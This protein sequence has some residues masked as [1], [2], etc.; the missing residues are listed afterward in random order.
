[1]ALAL[2][3]HAVKQAIF[4]AVGLVACGPNVDVTGGDGE[5]S[6]SASASAD[7][8][9]STGEP[10]WTCGMP[11]PP[12]MSPP[13]C[14]TPTPILQTSV[15][16]DVPTGL[17]LCGDG[18][19]HRYAAIACE[20]LPTFAGDCDPSMGGT[21][22]TDDDCTDA[23]HGYCRGGS[24]E[25][26][27]CR[28][29]YGCATDA[30]CGEGELCLCQG[31]DSK[32]VTANCTHDADCMGYTCTLGYDARVCDDS[33]VYFACEGPADTCKSVTGS[34]EAGSCEGCA[35]SP[36]DCAWACR[37]DEDLC[38]DCGRPFLVDG[39]ARTSSAVAR[40]DWAGPGVAKELV[41]SLDDL[42]RLQVAA[43]W[44][45]CAL[46]EHASVAA[47]ARYAL[48][49]L[50]LAAPAELIASASAAMS[51]EI[52][53]ARLCFALVAHYGGGARGPGPLASDDALGERDV[54]RILDDVVREAC[55]GETLAA[56]EAV[57]ALAE[58]REPAVRAA[59]ERI[60]DDELR[61]AQLGWRHLRWAL[62][63]A[64]AQLRAA[65]IELLDDALADAIM[66]PVVGAADGAL[67]AHGVLDAECRVRTR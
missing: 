22:M 62:E 41:S 66:A 58:A 44:Q 21:C 40:D 56:L 1:M 54:L 49:L 67:R 16:G 35:W 6:S 26:P 53:H 52:E 3:R 51:D 45:R 39:Q 46:A 25:D 8:S 33:L 5:G 7:S 20:Y 27:G 19:L 15:D 10:P 29:E 57:E 31:I 63:H 65:I 24:F 23:P 30:D 34:C 9:S 14:S 55:I 37:Y 50:A 17:E 36:D 2:D 32:C 18:R 11:I 59:L 28:C 60:A 64:D 61:H 13:L 47:F 42:A 4:A 12:G 43:H 38:S 48:D